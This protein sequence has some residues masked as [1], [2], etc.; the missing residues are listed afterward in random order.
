MSGG[1]ML[2]YGIIIGLSWLM[3]VLPS[4]A[5]VLF[6]D[7]FEYVA[8]RNS[9]VTSVFRGAGWTDV[10]SLNSNFASGAG[11]LYTVDDMERGSKVLVFEVAFRDQPTYPTSCVSSGWCQT[12][13]WLAIDAT[14]NILIPGEVWI[15]FWIKILPGKK[16]HGSKFFYPCRTNVY[17]CRGVYSGDDPPLTVWLVG[18]SRDRNGIPAPTDGAFYFQTSSAEQAI[19][20]NRIGATVLYENLV[21]MPV[22]PGAWMQV[23]IHFDMDGPIGRYEQWMRTSSAN[24]WTKVSDWQGARTPGLSWQVPEASR[25]G[26]RTLKVFTTFDT[27]NFSQWTT[28]ECPNHTDPCFLDIMAVRVPEYEATFYLDDVIFATEEQDLNPPI[29]IE[30][31][32][33][34]AVRGA[35]ITGEV[36]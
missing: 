1:I 5:V 34:G 9:N 11:Y 36:R 28:P 10:K 16:V 13:T 14:P 8:N 35:T 22:T 17:P 27:P 32:T 15:Q 20:A 18:I 4:E 3:S 25:S 33:R 12:D 31:N 2:R 23:R 29:P 7:S 21:D 30:P 6:S 26:L 19:D 24:P